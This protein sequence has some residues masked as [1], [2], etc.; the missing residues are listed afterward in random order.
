MK[1]I[2]PAVTP[3]VVNIRDDTV[4]RS[5]H[6]CDYE[7]P[8]LPTQLEAHIVLNLTVAL[9]I[10][11]KA[12][13]V[14]IFTDKMCSVMYDGKVILRGCKDPS[15]DL[16]IVPIIPNK[17]HRQGKLQT[18]PGFDYVTNATKSTQ[19]QAGP[20]MAHA[21][22]FPMSNKITPNLPEMATFTHSVHTRAN[23]I[24]FAH[25]SLCNPTILSL[26]KAM[27]QGFLKGCPNLNQELVVKYLNPS[28]ATAKG[29]MKHPKQGIRS[30]QKTLPKK[31]DSV[32]NIPTTIRQDAPIILPFFVEPPQY[33][34]LAY[35]AR[36]QANIIPDD[37][38][39]ANA[40]CFG[41]FTDK[42][43]GVVYNDLTGNFPFMSIDGSMCFFV[44]HHYKTNVILVKAI[45]NLDNHGIYEAYKELFETL[46]AKGYKPKMNVMDNQAT[47]YIKIS[48]H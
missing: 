7:I 34:G 5:T 33:H 13:C 21:L 26:M 8:G 30:T 3:L 31:G 4:V 27:R 48:P 19:S 22:Q 41:A 11:I 18:S 36:S 24:K 9:L 46:E 1:N 32:I 2:W 6:I 45:K 23:T 43:S 12:G 28:L 39:I 42:I 16:W 37:K 35:G 38:S 10:G 15:T 40:F 20:C 17:V 29:H 47:K 14:V 25:Q 44:M